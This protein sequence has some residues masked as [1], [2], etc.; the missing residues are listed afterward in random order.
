MRVTAVE[1]NPVA[2]ALCAVNAEVNGLADRIT[3]SCADLYAGA[4]GRY[5]LVTANPPLLPI[6]AGLPYPFVGDGGPDGFSVTW[7][8][9]KGL[10]DH[11]A[12]NGVAQ[13]IG[14]TLSDGFVP[15]P[16]ADVAAWAEAKG[17]DVCWTT[18]S[19]L[20]TAADAWWTRGVAA[21]SAAQSGLGQADA[22]ERM[23]VELAEAYAALDAPFVC[24][25]FL[26]I[27]PGAGRLR[28]LDVSTQQQPPGLWYR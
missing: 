25:C 27:T 9:L 6:P 17:L 3:V 1:V 24:T 16:L 15:A 4:T 21:T 20:P 2:A 8:I 14:M 19:H 23:A 11:L 18:V 28:H 13:I 7:R 22:A 26:R 12:G 10:P 5:D